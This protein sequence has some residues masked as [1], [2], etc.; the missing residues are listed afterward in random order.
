[1][2]LG[3]KLTLIVLS[4][5]FQCSA[6]N[7]SEIIG[8]NNRRNHLNPFESFRCKHSICDAGKSLSKKFSAPKSIGSIDATGNPL[9]GRTRLSNEIEDDFGI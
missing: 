7:N 8:R 3:V 4:V 6:F 9:E 5:T 2:L 1:M